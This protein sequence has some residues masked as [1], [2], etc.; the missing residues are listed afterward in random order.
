[1][2]GPHQLLHTGF[3]F[4]KPGLAA[5]SPRFGEAS[6][7]ID[8]FSGDQFRGLASFLLKRMFAV[9]KKVQSLPD[10]IALAWHDLRLCPRATNAGLFQEGCNN[11]NNA[12]DMLT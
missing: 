2:T 8:D 4:E 7:H 12:E 10:F 6:K 1:M 5:Q 3:P 11:N 9:P